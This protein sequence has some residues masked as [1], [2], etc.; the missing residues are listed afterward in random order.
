MI[1]RFLPVPFLGFIWKNSFN[2]P[3]KGSLSRRTSAKMH[4][5]SNQT[6]STMVNQFCFVLTLFLAP[7]RIIKRVDR[8]RSQDQWNIERTYNRSWAVNHPVPP[9][10][11]LTR[12]PT[13]IFNLAPTRS[14]LSSLWDSCQIRIPLRN[15]TRPHTLR[16]AVCSRSPKICMFCLQ[17]NPNCST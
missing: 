12:S 10:S 11:T 7:T 9:N 14:C 15:H 2:R 17:R 3:G 4:M 8:A 13:Q 16:V 6:N 5:F 1:L